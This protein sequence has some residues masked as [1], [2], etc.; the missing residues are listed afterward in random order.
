MGIS[1]KKVDLIVKREYLLDAVEKLT[2]CIVK[3]SLSSD[4]LNILENQRESYRYSIDI[5]NSQI[6]GL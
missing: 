1:P 5:L 3:G 6:A 2:E 4:E